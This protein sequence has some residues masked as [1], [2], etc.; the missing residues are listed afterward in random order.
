MSNSLSTGS[1]FCFPSA[2][3][4][5][6][7]SNPSAVPSLPHPRQN[8]DLKPASFPAS[9][10]STVNSFAL[11]GFHN[12]ELRTS[13]VA[14]YTGIGDVVRCMYVLPSDNVTSCVNVYGLFGLF[15]SVAGSD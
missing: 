7:F 10:S 4:V 8:L 5:E 13:L 14:L 15:I 3:F 2:V 12:G 6:V 9:S 1:S 11:D